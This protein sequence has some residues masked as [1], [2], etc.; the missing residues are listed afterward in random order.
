MPLDL[1]QE[2]VRR[3]HDWAATTKHDL[4][5]PFIFRCTHASDAWLAPHRGQDVC[6]IGFL[7]YL[8]ADGEAKP[9]SFEMMRE[10]QELLWYTLFITII[11]N[12]VFD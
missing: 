2:A 5:Y 9:G 3:L 4:H 11:S 1:F 8:T 12:F 6:W 10:L 7:V